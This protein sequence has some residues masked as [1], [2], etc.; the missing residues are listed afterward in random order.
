MVHVT[1]NSVKIG[2]AQIFS[3]IVMGDFLTALAG[4]QQ[5]LWTQF[6][7]ILTVTSW[8]DRKQPELANSSATHQKQLNALRTRAGKLNWNDRATQNYPQAY[9]PL[10]EVSAITD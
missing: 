6:L 4:V 10:P 2:G 8:T 3:C 7:I 1:S 5:I 9:L